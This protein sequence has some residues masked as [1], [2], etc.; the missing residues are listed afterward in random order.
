MSPIASISGFPELL[1]AEKIIE[2]HL[3]DTLRRVFELHGFSHLETRAVETIA[4]LQRKGETSKEI[5]VLSR[6]QD[7]EGTG[8]HKLG[9]HFDLT[10]PLA[11]YVLENAHHLKFPFLRYQIQ[12]VWRGERPQEGRFR[13]FVQADIDMVAQD[14]L[15]AHFEIELP[16]VMGQ[17]LA[18]LP[19]GPVTIHVNSRKVLQGACEALDITDVDAVL[20]VIDKRDKIGQEA[21][22]QM[23]TDMGL[24]ES[25]ALTLS[26]LA[27]INGKEEALE[28]V[29][30]LHLDS[31]LLAQGLDDISKLLQA[32]KERGVNNIIADFKIARGLDYYTGMVYETFLDN[33]PQIGS[34]CSGGRYDNL[35]SDAKRRFPGVGMSIGVSRLLSVLLA[36]E[37]LTVSRAVPTAVLVTVT[38]EDTRGESDKI[39]RALRSRGIATEVC[40]NSQKFGKQIKYAAARGIPYVWFADSSTV[41]NLETGQQVEAQADTWQ[42]AVQDL[43]PKVKSSYD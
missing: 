2:D 3:L 11:R 22:L 9:L 4:E 13:E 5:Y 21:F 14:E 1:P 42:P 10:V 41:K 16:L 24:S 39:A 8:R 25:T 33:M 20:T 17:A 31:D 23:L 35:V 40:P 34:I 12:K 19:I 7:R 30:R 18:Q 29:R 6:L 38:S 37:S 28:A 26:D 43:R 27:A 36:D 15:P 32:A